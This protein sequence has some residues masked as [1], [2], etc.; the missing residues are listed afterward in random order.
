[1]L[2]SEVSFDG[3]SSS[4]PHT[5]SKWRVPEERLERF[6]H[7][8]PVGEFGPL[9]QEIVPAIG[10]QH[11][12]DV[13]TVRI[14]VELLHGLHGRAAVTLDVISSALVERAKS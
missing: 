6:R 11:D 3:L 10:R 13:V 9:A 12:D 7:A 8:H 1:M 5:L 14:G 2:P 4:R